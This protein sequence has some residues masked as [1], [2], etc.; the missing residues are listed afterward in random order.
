MVLYAKRKVRGVGLEA[1]ARPLQ[2]A[3][4]CCKN[5]SSLIAIHATMQACHGDDMHMG[6]LPALLLLLRHVCTLTQSWPTLQRPGCGRSVC[7]E[8][9]R[10]TRCTRTAWMRRPSRLRNSSPRSCCCLLRRGSPL[11]PWFLLLCN[12]CYA[13][14]VVNA[15]LLWQ[16]HF[17]AL[18]TSWSGP[19]A[20]SLI[21][22]LWH[23][24][25]TTGL[26]MQPWP[27][28]PTTTH[29]SRKGV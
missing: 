8:T 2:C 16:T 23:T 13:P 11:T 22:L 27:S 4:R 26:C 12:G 7:R 28:C 24:F 21:E 20:T 3:T 15:A 1:A 29:S 14:A 17:A 19:A 5:S 6:M 25:W 9:R 18:H 10:S